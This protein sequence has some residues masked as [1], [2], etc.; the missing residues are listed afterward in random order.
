MPTSNALFTAE[1]AEIRFVY[2]ILTKISYVTLMLR[3]SSLAA[4]TGCLIFLAA[5]GN[6]KSQNP[7]NPKKDTTA[8]QQGPPPPPP[9]D[10][11]L[12]ALAQFIAGLEAKEGYS[13]FAPDSDFVH[14]QR[15]INTDWRELDSS[16]LKPITTWA[17]SHVPQGKSDALF[18]PF[19]GGDFLYAHAYFPE[20]KHITMIGLEPAGTLPQLDSLTKDQ[21]YAYL[22]ALHKSLF[23]SNKY[24][25]F[26]TNSM[27]T[28]F[29]QKL[30][31]GT[32]HPVL[33]H[34]ARYGHYI[35]S[36]KYCNLDSLGN[37]QYVDAATKHI[38][39]EIGYSDGKVAK[40][41]HYFAFDLYDGSMER[42]QRIL[43]FVQKDGD[44]YLLLKSASYLPQYSTYKIITHFMLQHSTAIVQDDSGIPFKMLNNPQWK[45]TLYGDYTR[46]LSMFHN[47]NQ[48]D[49]AEAYANQ[50]TKN[51]LPFEI[52]YNVTQGRTSI[53]VAERLTDKIDLPEEETVTE[54]KPTKNKVV[55]TN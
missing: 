33:L 53:M 19:A 47:Y 25:F 5:C 44:T 51:T 21:V 54:K 18:Y 7:D 15:R 35:T 2:L 11:G 34:I 4:M 43:P 22:S 41:L 24:G 8:Q 6:S 28:E 48:P 20:V 16:K 38:G 37:L 31:N 10:P 46:N 27:K 50:Q 26:R 39:Y 45:L 30:L 12:T 40:T 42:N 23:F 17:Q 14:Y 3:T 1:Q 52:G 13:A 55:G 9:A 32:I 29:G 36:V 49:L